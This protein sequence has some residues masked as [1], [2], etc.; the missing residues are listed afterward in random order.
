MKQCNKCENYFEKSNF[1]YYSKRNYIDNYCKICRKLDWKLKRIE[2]ENKL[3]KIGF[4]S[5]HDYRIK[6]N[7][8][9]NLYSKKR[10]LVYNK[11]Y[12]SERKKIG[13]DNASDYYI[14]QLINKD[15]SM[16]FVEISKDFIELYRSNLLLKRELCNKN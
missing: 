14:K 9:Y 16:K 7:E 3:K 13:I 8:N 11:K 2:R 12:E 6:T 1:Y 15:K 4:N 10:S 5:I